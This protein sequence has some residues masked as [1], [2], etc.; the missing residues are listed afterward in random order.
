MSRAF[1]RRPAMRA[2]STPRSVRPGS[3]QPV[4]RFFR[5]H[6]LCPWRTSTRRRSGLLIEGSRS[7]GELA[8]E[9]SQAE[10]VR[11]GVI[12]GLL[13]KRPERGLDRA[14]REQ[15]AVLGAVTDLDP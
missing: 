1:R 6:S 11:H 7:G 8:L 12:A 5:F 10:H 3:F 2:S 15:A 14:A 9:I 13:V 4:N